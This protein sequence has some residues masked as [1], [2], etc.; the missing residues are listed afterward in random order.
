MTMVQLWWIGAVA[1]IPMGE[2]FAS[3]LNR[4][5]ISDRLPD[6][7]V[8]SIFSNSFAAAC[9]EHRDLNIHKISLVLNQ[10]Q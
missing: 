7:A 5:F 2:V 3:F 4:G 9:F 1:F 8:A 10:R 6:G